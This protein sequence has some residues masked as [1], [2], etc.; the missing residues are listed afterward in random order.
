[1]TRRSKTDVQKEAG[2]RIIH[3]A[4]CH[5]TSIGLA[6]DALTQAIRRY[7]DRNGLIVAPGGNDRGACWCISAVLSDV[8]TAGAMRDTGQPLQCSN[9]GGPYQTLE[10]LA[11]GE[12]VAG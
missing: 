5:P 3:V 1:M 4:A 7:Q 8:L 9:W 10:G 6:H 12:E 2:T 11:P